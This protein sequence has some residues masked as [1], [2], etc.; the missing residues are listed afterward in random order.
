MTKNR[1]ITATA[2]GESSGGGIA[3]VRTRELERS[4]GLDTSAA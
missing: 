3:F 2:P 1:T 4:T